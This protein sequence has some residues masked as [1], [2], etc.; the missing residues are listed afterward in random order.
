MREPLDARSKVIMPSFI[1][2]LRNDTF[3]IFNDSASAPHLVTP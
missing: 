3:A 2:C 1:H